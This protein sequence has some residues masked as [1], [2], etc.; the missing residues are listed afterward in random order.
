MERDLR[1]KGLQSFVR[2]SYISYQE[3]IISAFIKN[4]LCRNRDRLYVVGLVKE[5]IT[6]I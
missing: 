6:G 2:R 5:N 3:C 4:L 1:T